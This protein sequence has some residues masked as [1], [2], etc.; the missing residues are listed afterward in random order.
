MLKG[1]NNPF[2]ELEKSLKDAPIGMKKKVMSDV[3]T[4]KLIMDLASLFSYNFSE[5][6]KGIFKTKPNS[7]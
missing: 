6:I 4:A 2:I 1:S 3:A 7:L 5:A